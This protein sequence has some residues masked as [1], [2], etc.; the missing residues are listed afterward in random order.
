MNSSLELIELG[1]TE[2]PPSQPF[3]PPVRSAVSS[4]GGFLVV[5]DESEED[6]AAHKSVRVSLYSVKECTRTW[7]VEHQVDGRLLT[8]A[9]VR[10]MVESLVAGELGRLFATREDA[11]NGLRQGLVVPRWAPSVR[12]VSVSRDGHVWLQYQTRAEVERV[13]VFGE[14]GRPLLDFDADSGSMLRAVDD[15]GAWMFIRDPL[16]PSRG[17]MSYVRRCVPRQSPRCGGEL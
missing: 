16:V 13:S 11:R 5:V 9:M 15:A 10:D 7:V 6:S 3:V 2:L 12:G 14:S 8:L 17:R 1:S 4:D